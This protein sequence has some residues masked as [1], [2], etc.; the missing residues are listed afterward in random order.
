MR[1]LLHAIIFATILITIEAIIWLVIIDRPI[2]I[3]SMTALS[4]SWLAIFA[5][6]LHQKTKEALSQYQRE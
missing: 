6:S 1:T 3:D 5:F 2:A 4:L